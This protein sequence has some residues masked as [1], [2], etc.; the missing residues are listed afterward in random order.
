MSFV[1]INDQKFASIS[2]DVVGCT[3]S[4]DGDTLQP[5]SRKQMASLFV[6]TSSMFLP[7]SPIVLPQFPIL[8]IN[9][10]YDYLTCYLIDSLAR[11]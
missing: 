5:M 7:Q 2:A 4:I 3:P 1:S 10:Y 9:F 6:S 8:C 11:K